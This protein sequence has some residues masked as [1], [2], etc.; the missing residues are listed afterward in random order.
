M[1]DVKG[2]GDYSK[3]LQLSPLNE[4]SG[5]LLCGF[6]GWVVAELLRETNFGSS[7]GGELG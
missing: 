4:L 3:G 5:E 1:D 6:S 7:S 2:G